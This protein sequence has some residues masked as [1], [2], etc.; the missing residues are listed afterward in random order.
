M[1]VWVDSRDLRDQSWKCS[2]DLYTAQVTIR[3]TCQN[4]RDSR[5]EARGQHEAKA[6]VPKG[7]YLLRPASITKKHTCIGTSHENRAGKTLSLL[8]YHRRVGRV[9]TSEYSMYRVVKYATSYMDWNTRFCPSHAQD[10]NSILFQPCWYP[11]L[12]PSTQL[13]GCFALLSFGHPMHC[14]IR[15]FGV[16]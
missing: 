8:W 15:Q 9:C 7:G 2:P 16:H 6:A 1:F 11:F 10:L 13:D 5:G 4:L 3:S 12:E 14:S